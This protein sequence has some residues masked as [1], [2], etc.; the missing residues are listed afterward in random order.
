M[1]DRMCYVWVVPDRQTQYRAER[2][3]FLPIFHFT[4][5][6]AEWR[7]KKTKNLGEKL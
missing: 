2:L 1:L 4:R 3:Y 7:S 5:F 6:K